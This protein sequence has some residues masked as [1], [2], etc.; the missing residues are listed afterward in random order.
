MYRIGESRVKRY[1]THQFVAKLPPLWIEN[2]RL[3]VGSVLEF[4]IE[5]SDPE[6]LHI[7]CKAE[8]KRGKA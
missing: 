8:T 5:Q 6:T 7:K 4:F 3:G 2:A 1:G